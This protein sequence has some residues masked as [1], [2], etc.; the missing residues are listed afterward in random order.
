MMIIIL[1]IFSYDSLLINL[2]Y[3]I[4][5]LLSINGVFIYKKNAVII[6]YLSPTLH[7]LF[8]YFI[9]LLVI[10]I[11]FYDSHFD[12]INYRFSEYIFISKN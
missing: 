12:F 4:E 11:R 5:S 8:T 6:L 10:T 3:T 2:I 1:N 9:F 7:S